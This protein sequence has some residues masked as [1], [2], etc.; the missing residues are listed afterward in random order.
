MLVVEECWPWPWGS[1]VSQVT[2]GEDQSK[3]ESYMSQAKADQ[4]TD[5]LARLKAL[6]SSGVGSEPDEDCCGV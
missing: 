2:L 6:I 4:A 1:L 3:V 5:F